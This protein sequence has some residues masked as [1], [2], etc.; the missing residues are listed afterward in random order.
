MKAHKETRASPLTALSTA[1]DSEA[2][3][4]ATPLTYQSQNDVFLALNGH[5]RL[6]LAQVDF[7]LFRC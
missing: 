1:K 3:V 5:C 2:L 4:S 7:I 6:F